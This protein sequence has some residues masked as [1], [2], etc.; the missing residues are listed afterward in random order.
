MD[1]DSVFDVRA[2]RALNRLFGELLRHNPEWRGPEKRRD[3]GRCLAR[4]IVRL[5]AEQTGVGNLDGGLFE[6]PGIEPR[7]SEAARSS[8]ARISQWDWTKINPDVL[9][10]MIQAITEDGERG[11][12]GMHYTSVPNILKVLNPLFLDDLRAALAEAA[13]DRHE[14]LKLRA[15]IQRIRILDPACGSGNFLVIAYKELRAIEA[16]ANERLDEAQRPSGIA[17]TNFRGIELREF[18]AEIARVALIISGIQSNLLHRG[19]PA[20]EEIGL[21]LNSADWIRR[22]NALRTDWLSLCPPTDGET[23]LCGNPPYK[24]SQTQTREQKADLAQVFDG[25]GISSR[26]I[27]YAGGWFMKAAQYARHTCA[28]S[29]FLSTNSICQGRG[30]PILWPQIFALGSGIRFA[31]TSFK[32]SNLASRNAAVTVSVIGLSAA[33]TRKR[34]LFDVG[35][36]GATS[37][38]EGA[39]ITPYLTLGENVV[40]TGLR[41]SI[42][43]LP[44]MSFGNMPVDGGNLLLSAEEVAQLGLTA[45]QRDTLLRRIHGSAEFIRGLERYCLWITDDLLEHAMS[46]A[47]IR[48]RIEAVRDLRLRSPD[49]G[50]RELAARPH[51]FREMNHA[52][53]HTLIL[54]GVSSQRREHLPVGVLDTRSVVSNL[55]FAL[56]DAPLWNMALIASRLHMAWIAT[57]CGKLKTDIRYS[58]T[59]GWN[60]FPVPKLS[61]AN[62]AELTLRAQEILLARERHAPATIAE[63]YEPASMPADLRAAHARNDEVLE[64][65]YIGR[66]FRNDTERLEKLF[67]LYAGATRGVRAAPQIGVTESGG[68]G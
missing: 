8:L 49:P 44:T 22:G 16:L 29:A 41:C 3:L 18:P 19:V 9:G 6:G 63:L 55:A 14:L 59:L 52:K 46:V 31:H 21:P 10:S 53:A 26:Q 32:W 65:I 40:V 54:A 33:K 57:V 45:G 17:L 28:D 27:D 64:R 2:T 7:F 43:G 36:D 25:Y 30:V 56:Y 62:K 20:P 5:F 58:N 34:H 38:R 11:V 67:E 66:P 42:A 48:R 24:G 50:T 1:S 37:V 60:T 35:T 23:Y 39:N 15:R 51:Q 47:A 4:L 61:A 12:L 13:G 68:F